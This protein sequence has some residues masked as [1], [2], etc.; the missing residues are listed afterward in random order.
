MEGIGGTLFILVVIAYFLMKG[1]ENSSKTKTTIKLNLEPPKTSTFTNPSQSNKPPYST[2]GEFTRSTEGFIPTDKCECGGQWVK[3]VNKT[4]GGR[5]F[6]CS[7][8]PSCDNSREKQ[9]AKNFCS[10]GHARTS[11]NTD[12]NADGSRRCL[13][14]RP[15]PK[16][17]ASDTFR[18]T[19]S[20]RTSSQPSSYDTN[21]FC[22]NGHKRT[23]ENTYVRPN[24]ERE[25]G[26]CR[27]NARK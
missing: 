20:G 4:T 13:I 12:Y 19:N 26:V 18:G 15:L 23:T 9:Q 21:L 10:N 8:Y 17:S 7:R 22:R 5:F 27:K 3:H 6:G 25:C 24:G 16:E 14:C 1:S 11:Q 2:T